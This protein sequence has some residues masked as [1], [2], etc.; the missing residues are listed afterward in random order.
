[1]SV[2]TVSSAQFF[3]AG[4]E[5]APT[6]FVV[7]VRV[8]WAGNGG[9]GDGPA[10]TV[11]DALIVVVPVVG[12]LIV[13]WQLPA[14][15]TVHERRRRAG[16]RAGRERRRRA[17]RVRQREVHTVPAGASTKPPP[18]RCSRS[19]A[20]SAHDRRDRVV[21]VNGVIWMF[22]STND[23]TAFAELSPV[24]SV[25]TVT[26]PPLIDSV[27]YPCPVTIPGVVERERDRCTA[28]SRPSP[29][30]TGR[31]ASAPHRSSAV[32]VMLQST[33]AP[34]CT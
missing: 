3:V 34:T 28:R 11:T 8:T 21:A 33:P 7:R 13:A 23:F 25:S 15:A 5:L 1:M 22:A 18:C 32:S 20:P 29:C 12:E 16:T 24:P 26:V 19:R 9:F 30:S 27:D 2:R 17:T 4:P 6:P 14:A 31:P 10:D